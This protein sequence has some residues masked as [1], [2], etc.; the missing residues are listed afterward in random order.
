MTT[1]RPTDSETPEEVV[2]EHDGELGAWFVDAGTFGPAG[3]GVVEVLPGVTLV[4]DIARPD[5]FCRLEIEASDPAQ[6]LDK[7]TLEAVSRL[8]GSDVAQILSQA[9]YEPARLERSRDSSMTGRGRRVAPNR[10]TRAAALAGL[11][12]SDPEEP[13]WA[14]ELAYVASASG[15]HHLAREATQALRELAEQLVDVAAPGPGDLS[16]SRQDR[17]KADEIIDWLVRELTAVDAGLARRVEN[18][19]VTLLARS[20][21]V[22][23]PAAETLDTPAWR[24]DAGS[25][26]IEV[27]LDTADDRQWVCAF[28]GSLLVAVAPIIDGGTGRAAQLY[29]PLTVSDERLRL[30]VTDD[31]SAAANTPALLGF[32]TS[33][34]AGRRAAQ[35]E[36]LG[37]F[38]E[39]ARVWDECEERWANEGDGL[40]ARL[41]RSY[42]YAARTHAGQSQEA[43]MDVDWAEVERPVPPAYLAD[44][45]AQ[46]REE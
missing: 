41:A 19:G 24:R 14:L 18:A 3:G 31:P 13:I 21:T 7:P 20:P 45:L 35:L 33:T 42:A 22:S 25:A 10:A 32:L 15:W 1:D 17:R 11:A 46:S 38:T 43:E 26:D 27:R 9:P 4:A 34:A 30:V 37:R 2:I 12:A 29:V 44:A 23:L 39:A 40:R 8:A 5:R 6:P 16:L 36:R 28:D